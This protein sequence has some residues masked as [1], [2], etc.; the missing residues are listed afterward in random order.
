MK[1][2]FEFIFSGCWH[3]WEIHDE[4]NIKGDNLTVGRIYVLRCK[5]CG[6]MKYFN[7][8]V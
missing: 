8:P 3:Q 1:R 6:E 2:L 4:A 5:N 7:T